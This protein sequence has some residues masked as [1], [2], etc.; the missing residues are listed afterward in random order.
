MRSLPG[1]SLSSPVYKINH[2]SP[3]DLFSIQEAIQKA[4]KLRTILSCRRKKSFWEF[5]LQN[6]ILTIG[7]GE[8]AHPLRGLAAIPEDQ[9]SVPSTHM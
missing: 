6:E 1:C 2:S 3:Q 4:R 7:I 9:S 8:M 5:L